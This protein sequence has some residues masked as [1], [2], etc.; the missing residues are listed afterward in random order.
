M[1]NYF[2]FYNYLKFS[3]NRLPV[4]LQSEIAEC[5]L[6]CVAM[7]TCHHKVK[8][9]VISNR[10]KYPV[11]T[12]GLTVKQLVEIAQEIGFDSRV[13]RIAPKQLTKLRVPAILHWNQ[14]HFV[15]LSKTT[16]SGV[17]IHDP[18]KGKLNI[19]WSEVYNAFSGVAIELTLNHSQQKT[20]RKAIK[21]EVG[22]VAT[23]LKAL[24]GCLSK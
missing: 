8:M 4:F 18:A 21:E 5:G 19:N 15:V 17:I 23:V 7:I 24:F 22:I 9:D 6:T 12:S 1:D 14:N 2:Q 13:F 10:N 3:K 20:T 11:T 16:T